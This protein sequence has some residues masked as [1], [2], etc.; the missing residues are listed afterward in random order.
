MKN[1]NMRENIHTNNKDIHTLL[2]RLGKNNENLMLK[3]VIQNS[4]STF[5]KILRQLNENCLPYYLC[6]GTGSLEALYSMGL[7]K[8]TIGGPYAVCTKCR[9]ILTSDH[10]VKLAGGEA[11]T[12]DK[13]GGH[14]AIDGADTDSVYFWNPVNSDVHFEVCV[15]AEG[16][17]LAHDYIESLIQSL[18][19]SSDE[20]M[21]TESP[22]ERVLIYRRVTVKCDGTVPN[23]HYRVPQFAVLR[24][25]LSDFI[26][27]DLRSGKSI[28]AP[29]YAGLLDL[30]R[31]DALSIIALQRGTFDTGADGMT[32]YEFFERY[33]E[34]EDIMMLPLTPEDVHCTVTLNGIFG[35]DEVRDFYI[36]F[37]DKHHSR[38]IT[39]I[40]NQ[41]EKTGESVSTPVIRWMAHI[42]SMKSFYENKD[43]AAMHYLLSL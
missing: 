19:L 27:A 4:F 37:I 39:T 35:I 8:T 43:F 33:P 38:G 15:N 31:I 14:I 22:T 7:S 25:E 21:I 13:C 1:T 40:K 10:I 6:G 16:V 18:Q 24:D 29:D 23:R 42:I 17:K 9:E 30:K 41:L 5:T 12:C 2:S 11:V 26:N 3:K 34:M 28:L 32:P 36:W 20:L